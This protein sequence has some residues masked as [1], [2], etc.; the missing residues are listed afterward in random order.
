VSETDADLCILGT[1]V[2]GML[3][4]ERALAGGRRVTMI[5]RGTAMTWEDRLRQKSHKDPI[6]FNVSP[7]NSPHDSPERVYEFEPVYNLGGSTN[8][9]FGNMPR[10]HPAHFAAEAFGGANRRW[11][12]TYAELEPYYVLAEQRL[13][14]AGHSTRTPFAGSFDYPLPP[15]RLAPMDR[16]CEPIFGAQHVMPVPT[17]RASAAVDG[18]PACCGTSTCGLCPV[19][20][21]G[22]ALNTVYPSIRDRV[23]IKTGLLATEIHCKSGRVT[24]ITAVDRDGGCHTVQA[25]QFVVACN[26]I[27]SCLLLQRSP[28][29]PKH[30]SLGRYYMDHPD[31]DLVIYGTGVESRPGYGDSAQ[32]GMVT[33]FFEQVAPDLPVSLLGEI[34]TGIFSSGRP[35]AGIPSD[36]VSAREVVIGDLLGR[37]LRQGHGRD[38]RQ[39]FKDEWHSTVYVR[40]L[41]ETQPLE[42]NTVGIKSIEANGQA[43]PVVRLAYPEYMGECLDRVTRFV[44]SKLP[45]AEVKHVVNETGV[46]HWLGATRMAETSKDGCVDAQLRYHDLENLF[47]LSASTYPSCS[48]A[49]PTI[50]L[51]ALAL[52]LGDHLKTAQENAGGYPLVT[53]A[54]R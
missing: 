52:R 49:N 24:G 26:G 39:A 53:G 38:F 43:I 28:D 48:S 29:V 34:K 47:V 11:P 9:F 37:S 50:T 30:A 20:A 15:H 8:H 40:F 36:V 45:G 31:F 22:T 7:L 3:L 12:I 35:A 23:E 4:A 1:G 33:T 54:G 21:K 13:R 25:K 10:F 18:R 16:A 41:V 2:A 51:A 14:V 6:A 17:V 44:R 42:T 32:T 5:E 19:N 27:D 46:Q